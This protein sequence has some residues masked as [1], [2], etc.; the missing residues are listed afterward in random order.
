MGLTDLICVPGADHNGKKRKKG[1]Y[2]PSEALSGIPSRESALRISVIISL[3]LT[4]S[5]SLTWIH[6]HSPSLSLSVSIIKR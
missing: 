5:L 1:E 3:S 4:V 6:T 2:D